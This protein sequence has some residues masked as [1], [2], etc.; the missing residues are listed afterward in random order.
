M[1]DAFRRALVT[2]RSALE[3]RMTA[4]GDDIT[5]HLR[6]RLGEQG[7]E[8]SGINPDDGPSSDNGSS[9]GHSR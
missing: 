7:T 3:T 2:G 8:A 6:E 4:A 9:S 5:A 1:A